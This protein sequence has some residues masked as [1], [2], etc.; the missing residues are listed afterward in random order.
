MRKITL[1][2]AECVYIITNYN[3]NKADFNCM[4]TWDKWKLNKIIKAIQPIADEFSEFKTDQEIALTTEYSSDEKSHVVVRVVNGEEVRSRKI[5]GE[6]IEEYQDAQRRLNKE[7]TEVASKKN[8]IEIE[9]LSSDD[10]FKSVDDD[11]FTQESIEI[12]SYI[13]M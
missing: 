6:F 11:A 4:K 10:I 8:E 9:E 12:L 7:L 3:K 2:T 13:V 5:K 1:T